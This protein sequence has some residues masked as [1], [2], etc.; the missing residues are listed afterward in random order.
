MN[1]TGFNCLFWLAPLGHCEAELLRFQ[2]SVSVASCNLQH[3]LEVE[4]VQS[5]TRQRL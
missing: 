1:V 4:V 3:E 2:E 5:D